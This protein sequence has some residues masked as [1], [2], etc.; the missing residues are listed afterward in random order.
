MQSP[1]RSDFPSLQQDIVYLDSASTSQL[2]LASIQAISD[3][4]SGGHGNAH[5]GMHPFS[6]RANNLYVQCK[7]AVASFC[8]A[9]VNQ[10]V[11]TKSATE[12][13][14]LVAYHFE[15]L[16]KPGD[17]IVTTAVE[18][19]ANL[20]PWQQICAK[21]GAELCVI[22][23]RENGELDDEHL[24]E[25]LDERCKL[26]A[27]SHSSNVLAADIPT[28]KW[29]KMAKQAG[30]KTLLDGA[31]AIVHQPINFEQLDCDYYVFSSHKLYAA[32]G[33][34]V[35]L[36]KHSEAL[37]PLLLG[38]GIVDKVS[39]Q[40]YTLST[41][42]EFLE[43]GSPNIVGIVSLQ[44]SLSYLQNISFS[45]IHKH[46]AALTRYAI[47]RLDALGDITFLPRQ[48]HNYPVISLIDEQQHSHD[49]ISLLSMSGICIRAGT[50]CAQPLLQA[51]KRPHC[52]RVSIGM[53]NDASDIDRLID[54][55]KEARE[56]LA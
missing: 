46:E 5:R 27:F 22:P 8:G 17:R 2:P 23:L 15:K 38:G 40:S 52:L 56:I 47:E 19:H 14:N 55:W 43:A 37:S 32:T 20:L 42:P 33:I 12:G 18:H 9:A 10:V 30:V 45:E 13:I 1:W 35:L 54:A 26:F 28:E 36:A 53:Y 48:L 34:G 44:A 51:L 4:L 29:L 41:A 31:Q 25:W 3:Y 11:F 39:A 50:H 6:E 49:I 16:L 24:D 7:E 21:T